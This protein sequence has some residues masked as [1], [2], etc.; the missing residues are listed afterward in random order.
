[1]S[2]E[3]RKVLEMLS[4]GKI[5]VDEAEK[6]LAAIG[7]PD[8]EAVSSTGG[9]RQWKYL[10]VVVDP[11]P[12]SESKDKVNI[13]IP[14]K[15]IRAGLKFAAFIPREY[16]GQVDEALK[17][18]GMNVDLSKITPEDLE[19]IV[20]NLDDMTVEVDGEDKVRVFCE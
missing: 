4:Q 17:E 11:G 16:Q 12:G 2:E 13:R 18:K 8:N 1:M 6:L 14:F 9:K 5:T 20:S 7:E 10:R 3:K 15:L 19:E